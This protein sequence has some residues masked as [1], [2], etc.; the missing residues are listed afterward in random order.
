M[1]SKLTFDVQAAAVQAALT[2]YSSKP[3]V[4]AAL[5]ALGRVIVNR[6]RLGFRSGLDPYGMPWAAPILREGQ[7]LVDTGRL[8]SS[9]SSAVQGNEVVV[10]T[11]LIYAPIHQFGGVIFPK[12]GKYLAF[13]RRGSA[14]GAK[15]SGLILAKSVTIPARRFLPLTGSGQVQLPA[16]WAASGL[17]AMYQALKL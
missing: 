12:K 7:P 13:P 16:E 8:R 17:A 10:G 4:T 6:V 9:I 5:A 11:N 3:M 1:A 14:A 15:A 2:K